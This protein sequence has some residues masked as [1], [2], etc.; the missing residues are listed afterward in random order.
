MLN[1]SCGNNH[2]HNS[3]NG[4]IIISRFYS[5]F[6]RHCSVFAGDFGNY[7]YFTVGVDLSK[8]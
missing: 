3:N 7:L 4:T 2:H 5:V 1:S 8:R 6:C